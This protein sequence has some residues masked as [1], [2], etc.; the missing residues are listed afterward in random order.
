MSTGV[1][2]DVLATPHHGEDGPCAVLLEALPG[3]ATRQ[4]LRQE[5][6]AAQG[7]QTHGPALSDPLQ[8][9]RRVTG[10]GHLKAVVKARKVDAIYI[11]HISHIIYLASLQTAGLHPISGSPDIVE[12]AL[13]EVAK[14]PTMLRLPGRSRWVPVGHKAQPPAPL[15]RELSEL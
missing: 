2:V 5:V 12:L 6:H 10:L 4:E 11:Y 3:L 13:G 7:A 1:Y 9:K 8:P 15:L 14:P